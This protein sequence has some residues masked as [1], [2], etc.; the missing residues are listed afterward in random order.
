MDIYNKSFLFGGL[1]TLTS[2]LG[3][4]YYASNNE[5]DN[6][7]EKITNK[8]KIEMYQ[9]EID[10]NTKMI[11]NLK[12][13]LEKGNTLL[14]ENQQKYDNN[15]KKTPFDLEF[16]EAERT[17]LRKCYIKKQREIEEKEKKISTIKERIEELK[18]DIKI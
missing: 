8:D 1:L 3:Y 7:I 16:Y 10:N 15:Q 13:S 9:I 5:F 18:N 14:E 2:Y 17:K 11:D 4:K 6:D 12:K